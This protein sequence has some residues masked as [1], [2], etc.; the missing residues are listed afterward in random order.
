ME[1]LD[2]LRVLI[3]ATR[4]PSA[5]QQPTLVVDA[6]ADRLERLRQQLGPRIGT[7]DVSF[8]QAVLGASPQAALNWFRFNDARLNGVVPLERWQHA[9]PNLQ[10][11][12]QEVLSAHTLE[13]ILNDWP[14]AQDG[15][16]G[17]DLTI[18]QG[19][20][21]QALSG[22]G[23][24]LHRLEH[25]QLQGPQAEALW[26]EF[27]DAWL[28]QHGFRADPQKPLCWILDPMAAK[29]IRQQAEIETLR[30]QHQQDLLQHAKRQDELQAALSHVFPFA[31]YR[32]QRPDIAGFNDRDLVDH[33]VGFGIHEGV[34]LQF[35][36]V[37]SELQQ[38]RTDRAAENARIELLNEKTRHTAQQLDLLKDL[39]GRLMVNP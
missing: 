14:A 25:I 31:T 16:R 33:F 34:N 38:L 36:A 29:A 5:E 39:I 2:P 1:G 10:L 7:G 26:R 28:E 32:Q 27:C 30:L 3:G 4:L 24:W 35:S 8:R 18:S 22:A 21:I 9:Y 12:G 19:D 20:P 11:S 23:G 6:E 17:I 15:Q 13:D 37:E